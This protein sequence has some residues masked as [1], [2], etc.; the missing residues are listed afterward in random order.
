MKKLRRSALPF[1]LITF[2][3]TPLAFAQSIDVARWFGSE[4][5]NRKVISRYSLDIYTNSDVEGQDTDLGL[6]EHDFFLMAPVWQNERNEFGITAR[7]ELQDTDTDAVAR[8]RGIEPATVR[9][10]ARLVI[11]LP[12]ATTIQS[13]GT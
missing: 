1:V 6:M 4:V 3:L 7:V 13:E 11:S 8:V 2:V 10:P 9:R 5:G 12:K